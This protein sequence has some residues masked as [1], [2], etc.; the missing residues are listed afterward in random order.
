M[1]GEEPPWRFRRAGPVMP[2]YSREFRGTR[3]NIVNYDKYTPLYVNL[4]FIYI[5]IFYVEKL[6]ISPG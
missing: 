3:K 5:H 4:F 6:Y 1:P 2:D